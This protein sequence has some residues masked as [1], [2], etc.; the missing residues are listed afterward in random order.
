MGDE[1]SFGKEEDSFLRGRNSFGVVSKPF[2]ESERNS[3]V[4]GAKNFLTGD[5]FERRPFGKRGI[6][7]FVEGV[8]NFL[9]G[10]KTHIKTLSEGEFE[11]YELEKG[12]FHTLTIVLITFSRYGVNWTNE[13]YITLLTI[14]LF[15]VE[16]FYSGEFTL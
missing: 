2:E 1:G 4:V 11:E 3:F 14:T 12:L 7:P 6:D 10:T 8:W 15:A 5:V 16:G 9:R 13:N